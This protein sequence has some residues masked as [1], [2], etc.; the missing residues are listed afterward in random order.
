MPTYENIITIIY[1]LLCNICVI[2]LLMAVGSVVW[3][4]G[5]SEGSVATGKTLCALSLI[6]FSFSVVQL[7]EKMIFTMQQQ[8]LDQQHGNEEYSPDEEG[9]V[10]RRAVN[11]CSP[12][13]R[14]V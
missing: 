13:L 1:Y 4:W 9:R 14:K 8:S 5:S 3:V 7:V 12:L 6:P 2:V 10:G 11:E